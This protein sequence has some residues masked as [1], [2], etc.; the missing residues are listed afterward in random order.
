[1]IRHMRFACWI[2]DV[3]IKKHNVFKYLSLLHG[4]NGY[5]NA[6]RRYVIST[7]PVLLEFCASNAELH[8]KSI[9]CGASGAYA[10]GPEDE[11]R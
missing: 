3:G 8:N 2:N 6:P 1:M 7:L 5:V 9:G 4:N 10:P 11:E